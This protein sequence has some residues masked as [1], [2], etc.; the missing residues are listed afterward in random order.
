MRVA[1]GA[2]HDA[3]EHIAAAFVR[4]QHAVGDQERRRAQ[5]VGD[6]AMAELRF[7]LC[8][9]LGHL[10]RC[11]DQV[12]EQIDVVIVVTP[13]RI[14]V[15]RSSPMPVSIDG[16]G[17]FDARLLVDLLEL[18]EDEI[19]EFEEAV[20]VFV[21]RARRS[22]RDRRRPDRRKFPSNSRKGPCRPIAQKLSSW[23]DDALDRE[24]P[25]IFFHS[26]RASSSVG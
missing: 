19:P 9:A 12:A 2:A 16:L 10:D 15:M 23:P 17:R 24:D 5:M 25:A 1:H 3:A 18:H 4:R 7:A 20:A 22:A 8:S 13:C 14:A 11:R 21:G 26:A 6:D